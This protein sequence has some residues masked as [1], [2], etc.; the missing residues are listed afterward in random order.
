MKHRRKLAAIVM[1]TVMILTMV[2][3]AYAGEIDAT[4]TTVDQPTTIW[5][6]GQ[7]V[8]VPVIDPVVGTDNV[9]VNAIA[10]T[11]TRTNQEIVINNITDFNNVTDLEWRAGNTF[12]LKCDI[13]LGQTTENDSIS[14]WQGYIP[15][16]DGKIIGQKDNG[17]QPV[18]YGFKENTYLIYGIVHAEI[19]NITLQM[20]GRAGALSYMPTVYTDTGYADDY[21]SVELDNVNVKGNVY[22][23]ESDQ[24]NYSPFVFAA[25]KGDF[26]MKNCTNSANITGDIYG[27]V[28]HGYYSMYAST[29]YTFENCT[30]DGIIKMRNAAM[31]FGN[32]S[33]MNQKLSGDDP[34]M[35]NISGCKNT[36]LIAGTQS[37]HYFVPSLNGKDYSDSDVALKAMENKITNPTDPLVVVSGAGK[38]CGGLTSNLTAD[39]DDQT[40]SITF[41]YK[42]GESVVDHY[43]VTVSSYLNRWNTSY[44]DNST[45]SIT[46]DWDG[47]TRYSL[48]ETIAKDIQKNGEYEAQLK[49]YGACDITYPYASI[50]LISGN[51][52]YIDSSSNGYYVIDQDILGEDESITCYATRAENNGVPAGGGCTKP[53]FATVYAIAED[54]S[55]LDFVT[56]K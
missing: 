17:E 7:E 51:L 1:A 56:L 21:Y 49:Y 38:L 54:G 3:T 36:N 28:F 16:F 4:A 50:Q 42:N 5:A 15:Y 33:T 20:D 55:I 2:P 41:S 46:S 52:V 10:A 6:H 32:P 39:I 18:I 47:T 23:T 13:D 24:S 25:N 48:S 37:A 35:I 30:N 31:F 26:T 9:G 22:L 14:D 29:D 19:S 44:Y 45:G 8:E 12:I 27:A 53:S 40:Q 11:T 43:L 34:L